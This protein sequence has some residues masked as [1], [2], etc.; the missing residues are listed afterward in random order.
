LTDGSEGE[1]RG[2]GGNGSLGGSEGE[3]AG[4]E[5]AEGVEGAEERYCRSVQAQRRKSADNPRQIT[6]KSIFFIG[7]A[8]FVWMLRR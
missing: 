6:V 8:P 4:A 2:K 7:K 5:G 3:E 1:I